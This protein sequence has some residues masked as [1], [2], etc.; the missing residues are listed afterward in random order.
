LKI[1]CIDL[2]SSH[3]PVT[4]TAFLREEI[5]E[6]TRSENNEWS[7]VKWTF[8]AEREPENYGC[9]SSY[10]G[11]E[12][13][14]FTLGLSLE[15]QS[16]TEKYLAN[17]Y[18]NVFENQT[19]GDVKFI[20]QGQEMAAHRDILANA[21][22]AM[23]A[24]LHPGNFVE[25][26]TKT[27][28]VPNV[29][30]AVFDQL[31]RHIYTGSAPRVCEESITEPLF[32]AVDMYQLDQLKEDCEEGFIQQLKLDNV[33]KYL[34]LARFHSLPQLEEAVIDFLVKHQRGVRDLPDW[35]ELASTQQN[36]FFKI[37]NLMRIESLP[38]K[39]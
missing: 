3:H 36:L 29:E 38:D 7:K 12:Y 26:Q 11:T 4:A 5:R 9:C 34:A 32:M 17:L 30:P 25:G 14:E 15:F 6:M 27:V 31:L 13:V 10:M 35:K 37:S 2:P 24:M 22:P 8:K 20:V 39:F 16:G 33:F 1:F 19:V 28:N 23:A 18:A 21:N